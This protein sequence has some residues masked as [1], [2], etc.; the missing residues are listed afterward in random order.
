MVKKIDLISIFAAVHKFIKTERIDSR[1]NNSIF[2]ILHTHVYHLELNY[3]IISN[4]PQNVEASDNPTLKSMK[5]RT[6]KFWIVFVMLRCKIKWL[7]VISDRKKKRFC[8]E[9]KLHVY[10]Q[11][12]LEY[13][14]FAWSPFGLVHSWVRKNY[15]YDIIV[16]S[17]ALP[18][19]QRKRS[20][21]LWMKS[22]DPRGEGQ[23]N[24]LTFDVLIY[25]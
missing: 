17:R 5:E 14:E 8:F 19:T 12:F 24:C 22:M 20:S 25:T 16:R 15:K 21:M 3:L 4:Y 11:C 2:Y 1:S 18:S 6:V 9:T 7:F 23:I 13:S 10:T